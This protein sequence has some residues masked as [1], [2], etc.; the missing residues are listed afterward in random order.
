MA[1][2]EHVVLRH[3]T[4]WYFFTALHRPDLAAHITPGLETTIADGS[5]EALFARHHAATLSSAK[6]VQRQEIELHNPQLTTATPFARTE[7]CYQPSMP[8]HKN[9]EQHT[10]Y[11][12]CSG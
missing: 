3:P 1:V 2:D 11:P 8:P 4:A 7:L 9:A 12:A 6:R 5:F 10:V